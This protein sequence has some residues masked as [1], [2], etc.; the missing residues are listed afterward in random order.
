MKFEIFGFKIDI[1][2]G[3]SNNSE[4]PQD[5]KEALAVIQSYGIKSGSSDAQKE[6]SRKATATRSKKAK[7]K[8][9]NAVNM[10]RLEGVNITEYSVAKKSGCSINTVKKYRDF[11]KDQ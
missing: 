5:L 2:K 9:I 6:A 10:L 7:D 1:S 8:I 3:L 4:L 11:I